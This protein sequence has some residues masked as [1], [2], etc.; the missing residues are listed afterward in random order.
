MESQ[1]SDDELIIAEEPEF[2]MAKIVPKDETLE[3]ILVSRMREG[4]K[5]DLSELEDAIVNGEFILKKGDK[6]LIEYGNV[7]WRDT[8][9]WTVADVEP[10]GNT[11]AGYIRLWDPNRMY[12]GSTNFLTGPAQGLIFKVPTKNRRWTPGEE[13]SMQDARKR[14]RMKS[15]REDDVVAA[16]PITLDAD[17]NPVAKKRG[18]PKGSKNKSTLLKEQAA[19][20][21]NESVG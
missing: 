7:S 21:T 19:K 8:T 12:F 15:G 2:D 1:D 20:G 6:L 13:E 4:W 3:D 16:K 9:L 14:R 5:P 10:A 18:R 17:G 11:P